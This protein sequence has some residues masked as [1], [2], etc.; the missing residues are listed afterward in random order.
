MHKPGLACAEEMREARRSWDGGIGKTEGRKKSNWRRLGF[1]A[2]PGTRRIDM[3]H[4]P[5]ASTKPK[6]A[7]GAPGRPEK[8]RRRWGGD[9][10]LPT[11]FFEIFTELP[12]CLFCKL[13]TIF[14]KKLK[15]SKNESCSTFQ[16]LQLFF[17][18]YFQI[19][20]PF[21]NLNLGCIWVFESFQNYSKFYM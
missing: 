7:T 15:I 19:L 18:E 20:P 4:A 1:I 5:R 2:R 17:K 16:T 9:A 13:L 8:G 12:L 6:V 11:W 3:Q 21:W 10:L 14:L